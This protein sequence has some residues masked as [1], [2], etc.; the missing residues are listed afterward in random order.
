MTTNGQVDVG[1]T[2]AMMLYF[3]GKVTDGISEFS[4]EHITWT[5]GDLPYYGES[6]VSLP[7]NVRVYDDYLGALWMSSSGMD[8]PFKNFPF[9]FHPDGFPYTD[10]KSVGPAYMPR[11]NFSDYPSADG[12][13][14]PDK[15]IAI[16]V[17]P[18]DTGIVFLGGEN[19]NASNIT[20][21]Q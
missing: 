2:Q 18:Q 15:R 9:D 1:A 20:E 10:R 14:T 11:A 12:S 5:D 7:I 8:H 4:M 21:E 13:M 16:I 3:G 6:Q 17:L 19:F